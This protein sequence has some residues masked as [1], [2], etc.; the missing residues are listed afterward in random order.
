METRDNR[1]FF[2]LECKTP[3]CTRIS[4][5]KFNNKMVTTG[6]GNICVENISFGGLRF[7]FSLNL[8]VSEDMIIEFKLTIDEEITNFYG[9]IVRKEEI[10]KGIYRYGVQFV[11]KNDDE[12]QFI[13][14][15]NGL[16]E[17][18]ILI[19]CAPCSGNMVDC[20]KEYS[21]K[22]N[23]RIF[24]RYKLNNNFVAKL[25]VD[26]IGNISRISKWETILVDNISQTGIQFISDIEVPIG[27]DTNLEFKIIVDNI[28]IY[29]K[30]YALWRVCACENKYRYGVELHIPNSKGEMIAKILDEVMDLSLEMG[31]LTRKCFRLKFNNPKFGNHNFDWWV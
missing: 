8:P 23:K 10:D 28:E 13:S 7:L 22:P 31:L 12:Q 14:R 3:I 5:V 21:G 6:T 4:I 24:K 30:G 16:S 15:L 11:N 29:V 20:I 19:N 26:T 1:K 9:Y 18:G 25:K 27:E 17:D 2:R